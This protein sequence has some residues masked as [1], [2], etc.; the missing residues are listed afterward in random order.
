MR[1]GALKRDLVKREP[2][3]AYKFTLVKFDG[4]M[5]ARSD[6]VPQR[7]ICVPGGKANGRGHGH[8]Q[9]GPYWMGCRKTKLFFQFTRHRHARMLARFDMA[10]RR[11]P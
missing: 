10:A 3:N 5:P 7:D 11:Q 9:R 8:K 6:Q 2:T 4:L 1:V